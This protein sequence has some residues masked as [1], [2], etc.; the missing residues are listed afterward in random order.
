MLNA[1]YSVLAC[2]AFP[3]HLSQTSFIYS[4]CW[5]LHSLPLLF[6]CH[7]VCHRGYSCVSVDVRPTQA[8]S[9]HKQPSKVRPGRSTGEQS[10]NNLSTSQHDL[11][12]RCDRGV[13]RVMGRSW[14]LPFSDTARS[15]RTEFV[16]CIARA[17]GRPSSIP[18]TCCTHLDEW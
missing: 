14:C 3:C 4:S 16:R 18:S 10:L 9:S 11:T 15:T 8:S 12:S 5:H 17:V 13:A 6:V 7:L 2:E 1:R